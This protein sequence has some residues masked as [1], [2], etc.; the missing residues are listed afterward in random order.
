[1]ETAPPF[2]IGLGFD[3]H[4]LQPGRRLVLGGVEIDSERG[5]L[6]HS[7]ADVLTHA[8]ADAILGAVGAADIG[9]HFPPSDPQWAGMDSQRILAKAA[10]AA[11]EAGYSVGNIDVALIAEQPRIAP[12][13][14]KMKATL[15]ATLQIATTQLGIKATTH[16]KMGALGRGEG[17]AVHAVALLFKKG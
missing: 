14:P 2:R 17:I 10:Q 9:H 15:A 6:G 11:C 5:L 16:E 12:F 1:M 4:Q 7:D 13:I 8:V 3:I